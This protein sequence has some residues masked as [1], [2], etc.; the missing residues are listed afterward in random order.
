MEDPDQLND[1]GNEEMSSQNQNEDGFTLDD[2]EAKPKRS[3]LWHHFDIVI[4]SAGLRYAKCKHCPEEKP[5]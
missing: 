3:P 2:E 4:D 5:K 1:L